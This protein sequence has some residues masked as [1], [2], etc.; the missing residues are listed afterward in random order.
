MES[1]WLPET[2]KETDSYP[3]NL[4]GINPAKTLTVDS[5]TGFRFLASRTIRYFVSDQVHTKH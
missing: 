3:E 2:T 5:K 1:E 4:E